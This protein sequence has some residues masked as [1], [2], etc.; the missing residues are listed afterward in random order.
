M[1]GQARNQ[2]DLEKA[3]LNRL[4]KDILLVENTM[5]KHMDNE[6]G[7]RITGL[8]KIRDAMLGCQK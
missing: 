7:T 1:S 8:P 2:L 6:M 4:R 3:F 5:E